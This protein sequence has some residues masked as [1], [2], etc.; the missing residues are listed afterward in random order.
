MTLERIIK[1]ITLALMLAVVSLFG[2]DLPHYNAIASL[3]K[4]MYR[5]DLKWQSNPLPFVSE[6]LIQIFKANVAFCVEY[7]LAY[8]QMTHHAHFTQ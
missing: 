4:P 2:E 1:K 7:F 8:K 6:I 5:Y 3:E